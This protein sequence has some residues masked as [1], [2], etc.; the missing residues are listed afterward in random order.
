LAADIS[1]EPYLFAGAGE[2]EALL[3]VIESADRP[4]G[5]LITEAADGSPV[6]ALQLSIVSR[7]S[8]IAEL[9]RVMVSPASR[10]TGVGL[11]A[12][13]LACQLAFVERELHRV[14]AEVYGDNVAGQ[15]LFERAGFRREGAR[16][17][18]YWRRERWLDGI[19]FGLLADELAG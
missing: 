16:R 17:Q 1:V 6:A 9:S 7:R 14:Q 19:L 8:G 4:E 18:A 11:R 15:R 3:E 10:R 12:V 5:L 2:R 13:Q